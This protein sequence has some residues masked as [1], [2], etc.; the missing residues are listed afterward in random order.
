MKLS[1][2]LAAL[3]E[4]ERAAGAIEAPPAASTTRRQKQTPDAKPKRPSSTWDESKRQV[5]DL[6]LAEVA[7]KMAGLSGEALVKE[8]KDALDR[9]L[10]RE[11]VRV[12]PLERRKFVQEDR[13]S[14]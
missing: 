2:K 1:E 6:V 9:I 8:V 10:Q 7:P 14:T 5:R 4:Q 13:K 11:D 12:S 3:E